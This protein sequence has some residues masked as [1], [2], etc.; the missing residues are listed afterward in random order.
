MIRL[1]SQFSLFASLSQRSV[2]QG[3]LYVSVAGLLAW[4]LGRM[5][6][7][8]SSALAASLVL[9]GLC[10]LF[11]LKHPLEGL[12]LAI[13]LYPFFRF[14]YLSVSVGES[15]PDIDLGRLV[16]AMTFALTLARGATRQRPLLR[17]TAVE[18]VMVLAV[19][20]LGIS[21]VRGAPVTTSLKLLLDWHVIPYVI[22]YVVKNMTTDQKALHRVLWAVAFIGAYNGLY[23]IYTQTTGHILFLPE[24][25]LG[26]SLLWYSKSLRLMRGLLNS[27]HVFGLVFSLAIPV[28]FY[29]LIKGQT[30]HKKLLVALFLALALGGL[31]FTYKRTA[32]IATMGSFLVIQFFFPRFRRL[33]LVLFVVV[34]GFLALYWDQLSDSAVVTE[35]VD[36]KTDS[37]NGRT[38]LWDAAIAAWQQA[39]ILGYGRGQYRNNNGLIESHYLSTLVNAGLV[40]FVPFISVF[41]LLLWSG[42]RL[43]R[44]R[45]PALFVEPDLAAIFLGVVVAYLISLYTV[46]MNNMFPH[47]LLFLLAG[48]VVGSQ[49]GI[50]NQPSTR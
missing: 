46:V 40:G 28:D 41:I 37:L 4:L 6:V 50:L 17:P 34:G 18:A 12:L 35:R 36:R 45:A 19:I 44:A 43:H 23:G 31:F 32:W 38:Q 11:T 15:V 16:V 33:F 8:P 39:P 30:L 24:E 9:I 20:G 7:S 27:P 21:A 5:L 1:R 47:I 25:G 42:F 26:N 3:S 10:L 22:Y 48:A 2:I 29:L 14:F 13:I 49:E